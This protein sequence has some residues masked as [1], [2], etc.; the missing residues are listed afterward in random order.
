M[1]PCSG[2]ESIRKM[3]NGPDAEEKVHLSTLEAGQGRQATM[4]T[5]DTH[6]P[7]FSSKVTTA[8]STEAMPATM[9]CGSA[10]MRLCSAKPVPTCET[11]SSPES[12]TSSCSV[13]FTL[14]THPVAPP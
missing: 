9:T 3:L 4:G 13:D 14:H 7:V 10:V 6:L 2:M 8:R 12:R 5:D 1:L 11:F